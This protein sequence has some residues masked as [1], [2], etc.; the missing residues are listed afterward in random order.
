ME[1]DAA[2]KTRV[3]RFLFPLPQECTV[4]DR[5][6]SFPATAC[7]LQAGPELTEPE[8]Q[9]LRDFRA[10][11]QETVGTDLPPAPGRGTQLRIVV[12]RNGAS[13]ALARAARARLLDLKRLSGCPNPD[14]AYAIACTGSARGATVCLAANAAPGLYYALGTLEQLV[15]GSSRPGMVTVPAVRILDWPDIALR[16][17]WGAVA[18]PDGAAMSEELAVFSSFKLN[19]WD[20]RAMKVR[21]DKEGKFYYKSMEKLL[22]ESARRNV[23]M[24]PHI[25]HLS[26]YFHSRWHS[27]LYK[28]KDQLTADEGIE[29]HGKVWCWHKPESQKVLTRIMLRTAEI[30][31]INDLTVWLSESTKVACHCKHCKGSGRTN[32]LNETKNV[33]EAYEKVKRAHPAFK[34]SLMTTQGSYPMNDE[35][36]ELIPPDVGITFY[37]GSGPGNTYHTEDRPILAG[38]PTERLV[39]K[40]HTLGA[41]PMLAPSHLPALGVFPFNTPSLAR[42]RMAE[43]HTNHISR[44][45]AWAPYSV[46]MNDVN[47]QGEA[48]YAWHVN[49]R[50]LEEFAVAWATRKG[51]ADP[52]TVGRIMNLLD[53]PSRILSVGI[54]GNRFKPGLERLVDQLLGKEPEWGIYHDLL[55]GLDAKDRPGQIRALLDKCNR[56]LGLA[57][58]SNEPEF[59]AGARLMRQWMAILQEYAI[60]VDSARNAAAKEEARTEIVRLGAA[61]PQLWLDW[62]VTQPIPKRRKKTVAG[63]IKGIMKGLEPLGDMPDVTAMAEAWI[64]E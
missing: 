9:F 7:A 59:I 56:A 25:N 40:G 41:L 31:G 13:R 35:I 47:I 19:L 36:F 8:R 49:G 17:I 15:R 6:F 34:L 29:S 10:R 64:G 54:N 4:G 48:E 18:H 21:I 50:T 24:I 22:R 27:D 37:G 38:Y 3:R 20:R 42:L 63:R 33:L 43:M 57:R 51:Y 1:L 2:A 44:I 32:F 11:W 26:H 55:K 62:V 39:Q 46:P 5:S 53:E 14:Q 28:I 30:E 60:F 45:L 23:R 58:K 61:I 16:G 12:G 52:G